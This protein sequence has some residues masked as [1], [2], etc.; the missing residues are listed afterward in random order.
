MLLLLIPVAVLMP[1]LFIAVYQRSFYPEFR[2]LAMELEFWKL[3]KGDANAQRRLEDW[4][5]PLSQRTLPLR[6]DAPR[7]LK[8]RGFFS[9]MLSASK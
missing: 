6:K 8:T 5:I 9:R 1:Q 4:Q 3:I 7:P 2:D